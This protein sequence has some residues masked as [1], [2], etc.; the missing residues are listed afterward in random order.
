M[1]WMENIWNYS[2]KEQKHAATVK[3]LGFS[4]LLTFYFTHSKSNMCWC[5]LRIAP[6]I[7]IFFTAFTAIASHNFI[8]GARF[9]SSGIWTITFIFLIWIRISFCILLTDTPKMVHDFPN[10]TAF[11]F[12]LPFFLGSALLGGWVIVPNGH[13][14]TSLSQSMKCHYCIIPQHISVVSISGDSLSLTVLANRKFCHRKD[15]DNW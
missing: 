1:Y 5:A 8:T 2:K 13:V 7:H 3:C 10:L 4:F 9:V 15:P 6:I 11:P 12:V 14:I